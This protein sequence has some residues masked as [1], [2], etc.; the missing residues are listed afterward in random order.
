MFQLT[1]ADND[2]LA[3][4]SVVERMKV[5]DKDPFM[6]KP[7]SLWKGFHAPIASTSEIME[8]LEPYETRRLTEA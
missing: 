5:S 3:Q 4:R 6:N 8:S 1:D 2:I 7:K